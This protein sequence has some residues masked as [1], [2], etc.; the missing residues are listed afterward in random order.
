MT[1]T[2]AAIPREDCDCDDEDEETSII[3]TGRRRHDDRGRRRGGG[4]VVNDG[5]GD[6]DDDPGAP[7]RCPERD[8]AGFAPSGVA[9]SPSSV[10]ESAG[11]RGREVE[12]P[13]TTGPDSRDPDGGKIEENEGGEDGCE[14]M[15]PPNVSSLADSLREEG[16]GSE[17]LSSSGDVNDY[18]VDDG[19]NDD[20]RFRTNEPPWIIN[21]VMPVLGKQCNENTCILTRESLSTELYS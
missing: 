10:S 20:G 3:A 12:T 19:A 7:P 17:T 9:A 4:P 15:A 14:P 11:G 2:E 13:P 21:N 16:C 8:E 6:D 5:G 18:D 1:M